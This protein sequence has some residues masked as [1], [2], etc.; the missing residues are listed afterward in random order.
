MKLKHLALLVLVGAIVALVSLPRADVNAQEIIS[1]NL[2]TNPGFEG[3][4]YNQGSIAQIAVPNGWTMHWLDNVTFAG[5]EGRPAYRPET[6]VWLIT[7]APERERELFWR[8]GSYTL[9]VFKGWAPM[10]AALSQDVSGLE[11]GRQYRMVIPIYVDMVEEYKGAKKVQPHR[12]DSGFIRFGVSGVGATWLDAA[13][14]NYSPTWTA[15]NVYPFYLAMQTYV[16]DFTATQENMTVWIEMGSNWPYRN[17]GFFL[18]GLGLYALSTTGLA[19]PASSGSSGSGA[20]AVAGPTLTPFPT[21]TPRADGAVVHVVNSGDSMWTIAIQYAPTLGVSPEEALPLIQDRNNN[22]AFVSVGQELIIVPPGE[23]APVVV[24][25][26]PAAEEEESATESE[27]TAVPEQEPTAAPETEETTEV[28]E[29]QP[30]E[31]GGSTDAPVA[32]ASNSICVAVFNDADSNGA[33]DVSTESLQ[34]DASITLFRAGASVSTYITDGITEPYCFQ[35]LDP[36][37]YQVQVYSPAGFAPTTADNWAVSV[38]DGTAL[39]VAFGVTEANAPAPVA[40][41]SA[42]TADTSAE[43]ADS[44]STPAEEAAP[45]EG[46]FFSSIGGIVLV[47]AGILVLLAGAGVVML[48]R[49]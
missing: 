2:F 31:T 49:G 20:P 23:T 26:E 45:E 47:I 6:V 25:E 9:K 11:V 3:G 29:A 33:Q 37:T 38:T 13:Q 24:E 39:S 43:T 16:W 35:N 5:T 8:D 18:D 44:T 42:E 17:N 28:A 41:A 48:R 22:P 34:P 21:P 10:Y 4:Y 14:I 19:N 40:E 30:A 1:E 27:A 7:D 36:D 12:S 15:E 46:G 32:S